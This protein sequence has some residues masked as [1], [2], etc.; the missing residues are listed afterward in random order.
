ML[1]KGE[2]VKGVRLGIRKIFMVKLIYQ[3]KR[4]K[5]KLGYNNNKNS[6]C[7]RNN[8][9]LEFSLVSNLSIDTW[10]SGLCR[11]GCCSSCW[12]AWGGH[13]WRFLGF[14]FL[15]SFVLRAVCYKWEL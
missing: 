2:K 11:G 12:K 6:V 1:R 15:L 7:L 3:K 8:S 14:F 10:Y 9:V 4:K 13:S 5:E